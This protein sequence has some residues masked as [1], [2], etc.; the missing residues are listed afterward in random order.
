MKKRV[1]DKNSNNDSTIKKPESKSKLDKQLKQKFE[2]VWENSL[3]GMRMLDDEGNI[4][5]VNKAFCNLVGKKEEELLG[6]HFSIIYAKEKQQIMKEKSQIRFKA[7]KVEPHLERELELWDGRKVWFELSNSYLDFPDGKTILLSIFR[8]ISERKRIENQLLLE[9]KKYYSL[10]SKLPDYVVVRKGDKIIFVNDAIVEIT[11]M[12]RE[13][14]I[15]RSFLEFIAPEFLPDVIDKMKR[16]EKG[17][18]VE[19]YETEIIIKGGERKKV[20]VRAEN[21]IFEGENATLIVLVDVTE[22][23]RVEESIRVSEATL[24]AIFENTVHSTV[25][26]DTNGIIKSFNE[27]ANQKVL[28]LIGKNLEIGKSIF[29][30]FDEE[31]QINLKNNFQLSLKGEKVKGEEL[32]KLNGDKKLIYETYLSPVKTE[33]NEIVGICYTAVDITEHFIAQEIL[34]FEKKIQEVLT[35]ISQEFINFTAPTINEKIQKSFQLIKN[36]L[37]LDCIFLVNRN[38]DLINYAINEEI[39][40]PDDKYTDLIPYNKFDFDALNEHYNINKDDKLLI[41]SHSDENLNEQFKRLKFKTIFY[42]PIFIEGSVIGFIGFIAIDENRKWTER[43]ELFLRMISDTLSNVFTRLNYENIIN[44]NTKELQKLNMIFE[45]KNQELDEVN[46]E[47]QKSSQELKELN[48]SKDKFFSIIA[49]D[50]KS[51]FMGLIGYSNILIEDFEILEK[52]QLKH[53]IENINKIAKNVYELIENLLDYSRLQTSKMVYQPIKLN[54][55]NK[56]NEI[57]NSLMG[58]LIKKNISFNNLVDESV[59]VFADENMFN[60][61]L[62]NLITNAIKFTHSGGSITI[63]AK[64]N[65][66]FYIISVKDTGIGIKPEDLDKLFRIDISFTTRGTNQEQ[67]TGLGLILCKELVKKHN[68]HI[69]VESEVNKGT[70]FYFS[71]PVA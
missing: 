11:G 61:L 68:G 50:L 30:F 29:D 53:F 22:I 54:V 37:Q 2:L 69:W 45:F 48:A 42:N 49:H 55:K 14:L 16:R 46:Q 62:V 56:V 58:N 27:A 15:G 43:D 1:S 8:D 41:I 36:I 44:R 31:N 4:I 33:N 18:P 21:I 28:Q 26:L 51:P 25:L 17:E 65:E 39:F 7:H 19:D 57:S 71:L 9:Q 23:R 3:D 66:N 20:I 70:T 40:I 5:L 63:N 38:N 10:I 12:P 52:K 6:Q 59:N 35:K 24:K 13:E 60:S 34:Q 47:L 64:R 67:G 32:Y